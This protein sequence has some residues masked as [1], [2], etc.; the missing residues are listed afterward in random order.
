MNC[1]WKDC[2]KPIHGLIDSKWPACNGH[3]KQYH[4]ILTDLKRL[5]SEINRAREEINLLKEIKK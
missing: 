4:S 5:Q 2:N 3:F 1:S